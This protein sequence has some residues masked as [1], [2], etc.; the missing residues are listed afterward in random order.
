M[1]YTIKKVAEMSGVSAR[2][3][4]YYDEIGLLTP[5]RISSSGY[6]IY[7]EREIDR[8][9][10]I[11]FYRSLE[12][13]LEDIQKLMADPKFDIMEALQSHYE[14]LKEKR[15]QI[16]QLLATLEK[17]MLY[18]KGV[19]SMS[20]QEKFEGFKKAKLEENE[21]KYGTEIREK[22]GEDVVKASNEKW[23]NMTEEE[24]N[25][26]KALEQELFEALKR[27]VASKDLDSEEAKL[28]Y[29]K[30]RAWLSFSWPKYSPE[31]HRGL[32]EMYV[33]DERFARYY[34][35]QVSPEAVHWLREAIHKYAR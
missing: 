30:H 26:M 19:I 27:L 15:N 25:Q 7:G 28:V 2:T 34:N 17:T 12:M 31:A 1:E 16:D 22:Y 8:L 21:K 18:Q 4:R 20:N 23:M 11:L 33:A 6:R 13:K 35:D 32:A 24:F 14:Q 9:Q 5:A 3:L 10:Q 29:E